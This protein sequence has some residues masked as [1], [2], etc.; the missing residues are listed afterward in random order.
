MSRGPVLLGFALLVCGLTH[1]AAVSQKAT[2]GPEPSLQVRV[3]ALVQ[4]LHLRY[5][6]PSL[7][8]TKRS[9]VEGVLEAWNRLENPSPHDREAIGRWL[10]ASIEASLPGRRGQFPQAPRFAGASASTKGREHRAKP[11]TS[12]NK[13][14]RTNRAPKQRSKWSHH[15]A[16]APLEWID[17]FEDDAST[18]RETERDGAALPPSGARRQ[19]TLRPTYSDWTIQVN[20]D[21]LSRKVRHYNIALRAANLG[22]LGLDSS[23]SDTLAG[24]ADELELLARDRRFVELY[25]SAV[26]EAE[27]VYL[28]SLLSAEIVNELARRKAATVLSDLPESRGAERRAMERLADRLARL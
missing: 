27:K 28:P 26:S 25:L 18:T 22:L 21:E 6:D 3:N 1:A 13:G 23:D 19:T 10:D 11:V 2:P 12:E 5:A 17:P 8:K 14:S 9:Q 4:Q 20:R 7:L 24:L 15:P 16:A